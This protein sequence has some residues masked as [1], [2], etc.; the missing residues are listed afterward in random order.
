M[1]WLSLGQR[2][3]KLQAIKFGSLKKILPPGRSR[4]TRAQSLVWIFDNWIIL[5]VWRTIT[6]QPYYLQRLNVPLWKDLESIDNIV[7]AQETSS[8]VTQSDPIYKGFIK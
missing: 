2:A 6:L 5:T 4:T 3:S 1:L 7:S 8:I